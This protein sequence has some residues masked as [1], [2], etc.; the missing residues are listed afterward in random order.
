MKRLFKVNK[1]MAIAGL[2]TGLIMGTAGVAFAYFTSNGAGAGSA[3]IGNTNGVTIDQ[4]GAAY[5]SLIPAQ[6]GVADQYFQDQCFGCQGLSKF[7]NEVSIHGN[8]MLESA[9]VAFRNWGAAVSSLPVTMSFYNPGATPGSVGSPVTAYGSP[10]TL[11]QNVNVPAAVGN[12]LAVFNVTFDFS[13]MFAFL[14]NPVVYGISF[15]GSNAGAPSLNVALSSSSTNL[16]VGTDTYPGYIFATTANANQLQNNAGS[17]DPTC[18]TSAAGVFAAIHVWCGAPNTLNIGAYGNAQGADIPA[19]EI[20]T[21]GGTTPPM[22]PG[23][24]SVPVNFVVNNT[25]SG[26][27]HVNQVT[28]TVASVNNPQSNGAY[29]ACTTSMFSV[30]PVTLNANIGSNQTLSGTAHLSMID[31]HNNQYNCEFASLNLKFSSN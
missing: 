30:A 13:S 3:S 18:A 8:G 16:T 19:V 7:G 1:R 31:D 5:N 23:G 26:T 17:G 28:V 15:D 29:E 27:Q 2:A 9:T 12:N 25:S 22:Y 24:P 6:P 14:P 11:T 10:V 4:V 20:D 21:T